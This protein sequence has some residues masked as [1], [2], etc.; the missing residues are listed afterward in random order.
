ME[1]FF[2]VSVPLKLKANLIYKSKINLKEGIR[3]IVSVGRNLYTGIVIKQININKIEYN[4][5]N[6]DSSLKPIRYK[7]ILEIIDDEPV[8]SREMLKLSTWM[9]DYYKTAHGIVIDTMLPLA[10]KHHITQKVRLTK[11]ANHSSTITKHSAEEQITH[12]SEK[13]DLSKTEQ[14]ILDFLQ[15]AE[16]W[17]QI[18]IIRESI[19]AQ[20]FYHALESLEKKQIIEVYR[21][22]DEKIKPKYANFV[23]IIKHDSSSIEE[24]FSS[25]SKQKQAY[26]HI[27][28]KINQDKSEILLAELVNDISYTILKGLQKKGLIEIYPKKIDPDLFSFPE[29]QTPKEVNL[30]YEQTKAITEICE[31]ITN[32]ELHKN[33]SNRTFLLYGITGS[34]KTEVYIEAIKHCQKLG[35]S[36]LML[37]PEISLT[38]QTVYRFFHSFGNNIAVLHSSLTDRERYMQWKLITQGKIKIVI[39]A[40]SAIFAPLKNIGVIIVDEEHE[41]SYKQDHQPCY[42]GRDIA[43]MRG[44]LENAIVILGSATPSLESWNNALNKKYRLLTLTTRPGNAI[45]P[46]VKIID[47]RENSKSLTPDEKNNNSSSISSEGLFSKELKEK[48]NDRL[49]K[50]EQIILFHNRRGYAN[51]LQ[52]VNCGKLSRCPDC[53]ISLNYHKKENKI[54]CHYCGY[55]EEVPRKCSDCGSYRFLYG[56]PGTEQIDSQLKILF[57]SAKILRMDS[58]TTRKKNSFNEMFEAM[59]NKHIDILIGTQMISKGLDFHNVTLVGVILADVSLN[60]PDFRST[61]RTFQLLT[62]VAGRSGRGDKKGEVIIQS[63][64]PDHYALVYAAQQDF[65]SFS[66]NEMILRSEVFYPPKIRIARAL[67]SCP[68]LIFLKEKLISQQ[69]LLI[70]LKNEFPSN[71]FML[72][73]FIEAPLPKIKN[74]YRYHFIIKSSKT[75]YIQRFLDMFLLNFDCP[76]KID[77]TIDV[78]PLSLM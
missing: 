72:L 53:D 63:R 60:I 4:K 32:N 39:G 1:Y 18:A 73:P 9:S 15:P 11:V 16:D 8:M 57:P 22:F 64:N 55:F 56:S 51:F 70:K 6:P 58:D 76:H 62:Q 67:F 38:P 28:T 33:H 52:C 48:I 77:M 14:L 50:K 5:N 7:N 19:K 27:L 66:K 17:V 47:L 23:K 49:E 61:E 21:T 20:D 43:V 26:N 10:L 31:Q 59:K 29:L 40:R 46:S 41:S 44:E 74:K 25:S 13:E 65:L 24:K 36:A 78:D 34:G 30:N 12:F 71:E 45:L 75:N 54:L 69:V 3:V 68:D 37:V 35:K 42:N 2:E